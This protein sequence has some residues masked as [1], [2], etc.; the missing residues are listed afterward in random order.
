MTPQETD[1]DMPMSGQKSPAEAWVSG[2]LL[3]GSGA[4]SAAVCA[5]DLLKEVT[6]IFITSTSG[7]ATRSSFRYNLIKLIKVWLFFYHSNMEHI[8]LKNIPKE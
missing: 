3:Q 6:I 1:P 8:V 7:K 2:G 5:W 4:R